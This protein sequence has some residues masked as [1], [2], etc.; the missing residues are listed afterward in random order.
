MAGEGTRA[1]EIIAISLARAEP[2]RRL[3]R[4]QLELPGMPPHRILDAV[5]GRELDASGLASLYDEAAALR[6]TGRALT[7]TEIACSASHL[8][9]YRLIV[10][11][12]I[13]AAVVL[14]DDAL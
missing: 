3:L 8:A 7:R 14:E 5:D 9:A 2:R 13:A 10:E 4:A 11:Q 1:V 6:H 12:R